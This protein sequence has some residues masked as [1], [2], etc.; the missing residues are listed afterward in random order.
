[1]KFSEMS[2]GL[3]TFHV[4]ELVLIL[5]GLGALVA[6]R[7]LAG[8]VLVAVWLALLPSLISRTRDPE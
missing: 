5:L 7:W 6:G 1:M 8:L 4:F 2:T 3:A